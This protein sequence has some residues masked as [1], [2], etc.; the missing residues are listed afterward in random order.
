MK[1]KSQALMFLMVVVSCMGFFCLHFVLFP[2]INDGAKI[3]AKYNQS[4]MTIPPGAEG[5]VF[6]EAVAMAKAASYAK[7]L[8][9]FCG[10]QN[11]LVLGV[12][13]FLLFTSKPT[14][15]PAATK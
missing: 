7:I 3:A 8:A 11:L 12:C 4:T 14:T 6:G 15:R 13:V 10:I 1:P 2:S 5:E 9:I